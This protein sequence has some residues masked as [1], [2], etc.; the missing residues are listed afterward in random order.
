MNSRSSG[1]RNR[2]SPDDALFGN[3]N[4][5]GQLPTPQSP[6]FVTD[7]Q[8]IAT[9]VGRR[10]RSDS[11]SG[12][13]R[14]RRPP[15]STNR[16]GKAAEPLDSD[17]TANYTI[18]SRTSMIPRIFLPDWARPTVSSTSFFRGH[19]EHELRYRLSSWTRCPGLI[20]FME[21]VRKR[22]VRDKGRDDLISRG[23]ADTISLADALQN[24]RK[25]SYSEMNATDYQS[26]SESEEHDDFTVVDV[27]RKYFTP[28]YY[29]LFGSLCP[30]PMAQVT[31]SS[32][33][34]PGLS[35][36]AFD[37]NGI[38]LSLNLTSVSYESQ[39]V[40]G[41][42]RSGQT[43]FVPFTGTI[44][45]F[46]HTDFRGGMHSLSENSLA[47]IPHNIEGSIF[48]NL[49]RNHL[50]ND[51]ILNGI[52]AKGKETHNE[53]FSMDNYGY[54]H[55][56]S[57]EKENHQI[58][59]GT[60]TRFP[61]KSRFHMIEGMCGDDF[62]PL[63]FISKWFELPPLNEY[64]NTPSPPT[65]PTTNSRSE[66]ANP[67]NLMVCDDC[68]NLMLRNFIFM[69]VDVD[70][71][72][73]LH[74]FSVNND[75]R[76]KMLRKTKESTT[77][78]EEEEEASVNEDSKVNN[79]HPDSRSRSDTRNGRTT[80]TVRFDVSATRVDEVDEDPEAYLMVY[81]D[82][83]PEMLSDPERH[84]YSEYSSDLSYGEDGDDDDDVISTVS[85]SGVAHSSGRSQRIQSLLFS[86]A[87]RNDYPH[88]RTTQV[89]AKQLYDNSD[90]S[91]RLKLR[92]LV[93]INRVTGDLYMIS[94]NLD[95]KN[96][97]SEETDGTVMEDYETFQK[98][99][100]LFV[101]SNDGKCLD[102]ELSDIKDKIGSDGRSV[103]DIRT[104]LVLLLI[105]H[106]ALLCDPSRNNSYIGVRR[107]EFRDT[108]PELNNDPF[109]EALISYFN[110]N[111]NFSFDP[112]KVHR[113]KPQL[114]NFSNAQPNNRGSICA[115]NSLYSFRYA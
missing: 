62:A 114:G 28:L 9:R 12:R 43:G 14:G 70:I 98:L 103:T 16:H 21:D 56:K 112:A 99:Y 110:D 83:H 58:T 80:S 72:D 113:F 50:C 31:E 40:N 30:S 95:S 81:G 17:N 85:R 15:T 96:W 4:R 20:Q 10:V 3:S 73:L 45:D 1:S 91:E 67:E 79:D 11:R 82:M 24:P 8:P 37:L 75:M 34:Q 78:S 41:Y 86:P 29:P 57:Q 22:R 18:Q 102:K 6:N 108:E 105:V 5:T 49:L 59:Y 88:F 7:D 109:C 61:C 47:P 13:L 64:V 97:S 74:D 87:T 19:M 51:E 52:V 38:D 23:T 60:D 54:I 106:P 32:F 76:F 27:K 84:S 115:L 53:A 44:I 2:R 94:G 101:G 63:K 107:T 66:Y 35:F 104:L 89:P 65:P 77:R 90:D 71:E 39:T 111:V 92:M 69:I 33:L 100:R 48:D 93:S 25:R 55:Y 42:F 26:E 46:L 36:N 68:I